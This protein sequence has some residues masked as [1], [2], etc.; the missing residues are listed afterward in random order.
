MAVLRP[1]T[2]AVPL[3]QLAYEQLR[4]ALLRGELQRG[5]RLVAGEL[6]ERFGM[7]RTPVRDAL[8]RMALSGVIEPEGSGFV[9]A[10][11]TRRD[12]RELF[13]LRVLLEGQA[14]AEAARQDADARGHL[15][16]ALDDILHRNE[17]TA[18]Q[19]GDAFHVELGGLAGGSSL[20][21]AVRLLNDRILPVRRDLSWP[22][23]GRGHRDVRDAIEAG[24]SDRAAAAMRAHLLAG[25]HTY[26]AE[27][28][29]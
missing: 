12:V 14:A 24:D 15:V 29:L 9:P 22:D 1:V 3:S 18:A 11:P 21:Q 26:V 5:R 23:A 19:R 4:D 17:V 28:A 7:S 13:E 10:W 16:A 2:R 20:S 25:V 6:A 8:Q 27:V